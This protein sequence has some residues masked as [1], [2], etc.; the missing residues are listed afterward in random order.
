MKILTLQIKKPYLDAILSGEKTKEYREI[1]PKNADK[2]VIQDPDA[3]DEADWLKPIEYDAIRFFNGYATNRPEVLI[4][5]KD[6]FI[7]ILTDDEGND[8]I[9]EEDGE[10]YIET[11]MIYTLGKVLEKKNI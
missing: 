2:Y 7:Q 8:I 4:E 6:A 9:Y 3:E 1:R 10:E 5:V 11:M